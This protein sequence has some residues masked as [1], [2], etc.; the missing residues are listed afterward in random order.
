MVNK[1]FLK[2]KLTTIPIQV[3]NIKKKY[4]NVK[5][6]ENTDN[7]LKIIVK[8]Q[9]TSISK[10]YDTLIEFDIVKKIPKVMI[11]LK[12]LGV[13]KIETIPHN[14]QTETVQNEKYL[15]LC[16]YY[17]GEWN[18]KMNISDTIIPWASEWLYYFE[19]WKITGKWLGGGIEHKNKKIC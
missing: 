8:L 13:E 3:Y 9:P 6:I 18:S 10:Y 16:L 4:K 1:H 17:P 15:I 5:F 14:Y 7:K 12:Q 19:I 11:S 2:K